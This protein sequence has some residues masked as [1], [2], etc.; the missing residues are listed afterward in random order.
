MAPVCVQRTGRSKKIAKRL[1]L[2]LE[3]WTFEPRPTKCPIFIKSVMNKGI[4]DHIQIIFNEVWYN[5]STYTAGIFNNFITAQA[6]C[7]ILKCHAQLR[8]DG[9][10]K[11]IKKGICCQHTHCLSSSELS[12]QKLPYHLPGSYCFS[13]FCISGNRKIYGRECIPAFSFPRRSVGRRWS[14]L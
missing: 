12:K 4:E 9:K 14:V 8:R 13:V 10:T 11:P 7:Q 1:T 5:T 6:F 2:N 3:P